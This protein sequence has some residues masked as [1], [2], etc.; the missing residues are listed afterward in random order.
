MTAAQTREVDLVEQELGHRAPGWAWPLVAVVVG[1]VGGLVMS[2]SVAGHSLIGARWHFVVLIALWVPAWAA[3]AWGA[4]RLPLRWALAAV[5]VLAVLLRL[6][7]ASGTTASISNDAER[8]AWDA[9]VQL[10]GADPYRY[11]P[12]APQLE[13]LRTAGFWPAPVACHHLRAKSG[14]TVLNRAHVRTIYPAVAEAWFVAVD[15]TASLV[16]GHGFDGG[17]AGYRPWQLAGGLVD[18]LAIVLMI[19]LLRSQGRDPRLVAWYALSPV[20]VI[21]FA[22]NGHVDGFSLA[23]LLGAF[24]ALRRDRPVLAGIL[25]G[26]ATMV[27]LYP[28]AAVVAGWRQGRWRMLLPAVAVMVVSEAPHVVAVGTRV[29]GYLPGY[30][31]EEHYGTGGRFLLLDILHL[32]AMATIALAVFGLA[33]A[34]IVVL[35]RRWSPEAGTAF[36]LVVLIGITTPVQPW[37]AVAV[38]GLALSAGLPC[39][40]LL[41]LLAEGYY[42]SVV[43]DS[44][45][46]ILVGRLAYGLPLVVVVAL[47]VAQAIGARRRGAGGELFDDRVEGLWDDRALFRREL[48]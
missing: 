47:L 31:K 8:Y 10:S 24:L 3:A 48:R 30:L 19:L 32:P 1:G 18:D 13:H 6:A 9:H 15:V 29:L 42:A 22:G 11:P 45:H 27:K 16:T 38:A 40:I 5:L 20:A 23:L 21:E 37:Y 4:R 17:G 14:C 34:M 26:A 41:P 7:A 35:V 43:L 12:A 2:W 33:A 25:I 36:V 46:Q 39:L 28:G 44:H